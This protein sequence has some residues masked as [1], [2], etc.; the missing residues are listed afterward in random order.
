MARSHQLE[1]EAAV[2]GLVR[3]LP[4]TLRGIRAN[5]ARPASSAKREAESV[6]C[7]RAPQ[8]A[9][10]LV[11]GF[12]DS[13]RHPPKF[14]LFL[15]KFILF[16]FRSVDYAS[17]PS[18]TSSPLL[19]HL[20]PFLTGC[21]KHGRRQLFLNYS[22]TLGFSILSKST[23]RAVSRQFTDVV[24]LL[25]SR[26]QEWMGLAFVRTKQLPAGNPAGYPLIFRLP[27]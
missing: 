23:G 15:K 3:F 22:N 12:R 1:E 8:E 16:S 10:L 18:C 9:A 24:R 21:G 6:P 11:P 2:F 19:S 17:S 13:N 20:S 14:K 7:H 25:S 26:G 27:P 4:A 5:S